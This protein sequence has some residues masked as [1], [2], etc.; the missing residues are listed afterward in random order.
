[1]QWRLDPAREIGERLR[2]FEGVRAIVAVGSVA[3]GYA[4][5]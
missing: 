2:H 3:R 1:M 4:E 5:E